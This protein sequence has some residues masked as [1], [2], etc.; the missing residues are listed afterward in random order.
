MLK[1]VLVALAVGVF[2]V[3][4]SPMSAYAA[5]P[6]HIAIDCYDNEDVDVT[7]PTVDVPF[8]ADIILDLNDP[9]NSGN[10]CTEAQWSPDPTDTTSLLGLRSFTISNADCASKSYFIVEKDTGMHDYITL[11]CLAAPPATDEA[12]PNTGSSASVMLGVGISA[13]AVILMGAAALRLR[14]RKAAQR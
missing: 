3:G 2:A 9:S 7:H 8:G 11:N 10:D 13:F 5:D 12:L 14:S 1:K 6:V 4:I